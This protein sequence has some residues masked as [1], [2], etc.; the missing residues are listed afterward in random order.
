MYVGI[1]LM[2]DGHL[3]KVAYT[4]MQRNSRPSCLHFNL[5]LAYL[6]AAMLKLCVII[7]QP[8]LM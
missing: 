7:P 8:L 5:L 4:L 6:K 3:K 1:P 2:V